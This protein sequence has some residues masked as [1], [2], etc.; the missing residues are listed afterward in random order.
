MFQQILTIDKNITILIYQ[1][2]PRFLLFDWIS[3]LLNIVSVPFFLWAIILIIV[4]NR[5]KPLYFIWLPLFN[6]L[7]AGG[8]ANYILKNIFERLRP[9]IYDI[10]INFSCPTDFSFPSGHAA[11]SFAT[12]TTIALLDPKRKYL[13]YSIALII[14][15]SR[16]YLGVH[17][18]FDVIGGIV[19]GTIISILSIKILHYI[20]AYKT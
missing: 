1:Y 16:V 8:I 13:Y 6:L 10:V 5:K 11:T 17:Y 3:Q 15:I 20:K 14:S 4:Y 9:C 12:A 18:F 19:S 2:I 7:V